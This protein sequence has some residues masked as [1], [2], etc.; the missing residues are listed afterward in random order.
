MRRVALLL[1]CSRPISWLNTA[2]PFLAG[3]IIAEKNVSVFAIVATIFFMFPYNLLMYGVNDV[4]D[5][6][7]DLKN[8]RKG[9]LE[10]AKVRPIDHNFVVFT[11]LAVSLPFLVYM[12]L[13]G[14]RTANELLLLIIFMV[15]AYSV[16]VLRFKERPILDSVTSSIHFVG[17]LLYALVLTG[18][19]ISY[20]PYVVAF[21]FWGMASHAFGAVQDI[22]ADRAAGIGSIA[23]AFG[24]RWTIVFSV[25]CYTICAFTLA[26]VDATGLLLGCIAV[27]YAI[28]AGRFIGITNQNAEETNRGWKVFMRLNWLAGAVITIVIIQYLR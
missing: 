24:A 28:N 25:I 5:F 17:P 20:T 16:P 1:R 7:S 23:T 12:L 27:A 15:L 8:P 2:Y 10:G 21:F 6:E 14:S 19:D 9:G 26:S 18:W 3:Y 4:Y 13:N 11:A 22:V